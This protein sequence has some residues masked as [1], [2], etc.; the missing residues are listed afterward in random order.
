MNFRSEATQKTVIYFQLLII[1]PT[2]KNY[3]SDIKESP[4]I[5]DELQ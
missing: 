1:I 2:M 5:D 3:I 4:E